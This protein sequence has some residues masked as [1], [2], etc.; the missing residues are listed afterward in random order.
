MKKFLITLSA[1]LCLSATSA[2]AA[3]T[4]EFTI[5]SPTMSVQ[6]DSIVANTLDAAPYIKNDRTM[7]PVYALGTAFGADV[8]WDG[9]TRTV[10]I[11]ANGKNVKLTIDSDVITVDG[12]E[13]KID[14]PAEITSDRT[15]LPLRAVSENLGYYVYYVHATRQIIVDDTK[16][17]MT[18]NGTAIPYCLFKNL[19]L[20]NTVDGDAEY[21]AQLIPQLY[22]YYGEIYSLFENASSQNLTPE[23]NIAVS[24]EIALMD[25]SLLLSA[26]NAKFLQDYCLVLKYLDSEALNISISDEEASSYYNDNYVCAK[27]VLVSIDE[28]RKETEA[29]KIAN[30]VYN[31]AKAKVDFDKLIEEYGED[32]G[33]AQNPDGYIFTH[34]EMVSEF[35][36]AAFTLK[37]GEISKPVKTVYGY[38]VIKKLELPQ[39]ETV[40][41]EIKTGIQSEK[42]SAMVT[43]T[44][45][46]AKTEIH[47]TPEELTK[48]L[49]K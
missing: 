39:D 44:V 12:S 22:D 33:M 27:H 6:T 31:S 41:T 35:E 29:L 49:V 23:E 40:L 16:P 13:V 46:N 28:N 25:S 43:E 36:E 4:A 26:P 7:I 3:T 24:N 14:C 8:Q 30:K 17:V 37:A 15:F 21:N 18:I 38:H 42:L 5:D 32:P 2:L 47:I 11:K 34:G 20:E 19:Y 10:D 45:S 48:L 1:L 9:N